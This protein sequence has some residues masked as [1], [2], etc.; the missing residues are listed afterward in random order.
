MPRKADAAG[1]AAVAMSMLSDGKRQEAKRKGLEPLQ[2]RTHAAEC[3]E[4]DG[5]VRMGRNGEP[6]EGRD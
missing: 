4:S 5:V 6:C 3:N 1:T 2:N